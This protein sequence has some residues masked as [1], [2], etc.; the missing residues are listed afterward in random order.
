[1]ILSEEGT[2]NDSVCGRRVPLMILWE[3]GTI[4]DSV[5]GGYH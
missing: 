2:I 5:G 3:E 1:M 4:N